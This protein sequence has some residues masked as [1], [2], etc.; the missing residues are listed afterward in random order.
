M[1]KFFVYRL[2]I[3]TA[4]NDARLSQQPLSGTRLAHSELSLHQLV[5]SLARASC[6]ECG[7]PPPQWCKY[8]DHWGIHEERLVALLLSPHD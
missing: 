4:V 8:G 3:L 7:A 1:S 6:P 5:L 2:D